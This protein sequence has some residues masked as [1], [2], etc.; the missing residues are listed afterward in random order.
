MPVTDANSHFQ[1]S[2]AEGHRDAIAHCGAPLGQII[3]STHDFFTGS[4]R[5][6]PASEQTL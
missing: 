4:A 1:E 2:P 5:R 3:A 6:C